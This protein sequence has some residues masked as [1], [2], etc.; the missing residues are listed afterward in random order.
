MHVPACPRSRPRLPCLQNHSNEDIYEKAVAILETYF[1]VEDGEEENLAPAVAEGGECAS[2]AVRCSLREWRGIVAWRP[3]AFLGD[4][5]AVCCTDSTIL[6][7]PHFATL[8]PVT[9]IPPVCAAQART[10]LAPRPRGASARRHRR[11]ASTLVRKWDTHS[12][13]PTPPSF[14]LLMAGGSSLHAALASLPTLLFLI[15]A[16]ALVSVGPGSCQTSAPLLC[17]PL[18][19]H[20]FPALFPCIHCQQTSKI[21]L[22]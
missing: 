4:P 5:V 19:L 20:A 9:V 10:P 15:G 2:E 22:A 7:A 14:H 13:A 16:G 18:L 12:S 6:V 3:V 8:T 17:C 1:D 21:M 11:A